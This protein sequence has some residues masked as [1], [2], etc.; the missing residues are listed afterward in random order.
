[1]IRFTSV[2]RLFTACR[3]TLSRST[4]RRSQFAPMVAEI[5]EC[6]QL[7]AASGLQVVH[8]SGQSFVTWQ[9]DTSV[10]GEGYHVYRS[11]TAITAANIAQAQQLTSKWGALDD[12]T[13]HHPLTGVGAPANFVI[14]DLGAPLSDDQGLFV[15]TIPAGQ[16][17]NY[18]YAVT[19]V[20]NGI[21][22]KTLTSGV[23]SLSS[24]VTE[25]VAVPQPVLVSSINN[26][27]GR[28]YTQY[29]DYDNWNPTFEGYAYNY[30]VALPQNYD[31]NVAWPL[32]LM[33]HAYG[34]RYRLES[35]SDFDWP[36]IE[37]FPDDGGAQSGY[38]NTWWYG[39]AA[40]HNY[41][42]D[43]LIPTSG[44][45]ENFT[46]QRLFQMIDQVKANFTVDVNAI[47]AQG[48]SMGASGSL[49]LG[50]RYGDVFAWIFA[51]EPMTNYG[52]NPLFQGQFEELWGTQ[53]SNLPI[54]NKGPYA[55]RLV[56]YNGTGVY[57]WMNHQEMLGVMRNE[58]MAMLMVGH[59]KI[60]D[61]IDWQTQGR[62]IIA[63]LNNAHVAFTAEQRD[64]WDHNW[65]GFDYMND[66]MFGVPVYG[67][68]DW[69][70]R[71][72]SSLIAFSNASGSGALVPAPTGTD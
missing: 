66:A 28:V 59:G 18:F 9:E 54:V 70:F 41:K 36:V 30:S 27:H 56:K 20:V 40:D 69:I 24:G 62:P 55:S 46:E 42:T 5:L 49:S 65:M 29:M 68:T 21:E 37:V 4:R 44:H 48:H 50:M 7:L 47:H 61:V 39:F 34:E 17:G 52:T 64:N 15:Y 10:A 53:A 45:I 22:N 26:G 57:D 23:N 2:S 35:F 14:Q 71:K 31:P 32:R 13:S 63:A 67:K 3:R 38:L 25:N 43:G 19:E 8:R 6:R 51:S 11:T 1:M 72:D 33:P 58:P 60:D 12:N 16:S